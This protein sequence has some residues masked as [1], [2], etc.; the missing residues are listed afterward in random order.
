M[1]NG[2]FVPNGNQSPTE[3]TEEKKDPGPLAPPYCD[4]EY[5]FD[6]AFKGDSGSKRGESEGTKT[7]TGLNPFPGWAG[8]PNDEFL[9]TV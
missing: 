8:D 2:T 6:P 4:P 9:V 7:D 5:Y 1:T 3:P